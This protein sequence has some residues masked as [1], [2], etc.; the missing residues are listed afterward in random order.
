MKQW[1]SKYSAIE[2]FRKNGFIYCL[3]LEGKVTLLYESI[4]SV[5]DRWGTC[6]G[7][8]VYIKRVRPERTIGSLILPAEVR[9]P[10]NEDFGKY[11]W[12]F[13]PENKEK[14]IEKYYQ[15]ERQYKPFTKIEDFKYNPPT[16]T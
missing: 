7:F 2:R 8:E 6:A 13:Y 14:A 9:M 1:M 4:A 5:D 15:I 3:R 16:A 11:A 10:S 12:S